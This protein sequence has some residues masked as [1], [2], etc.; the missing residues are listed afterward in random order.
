MPR[1]K[2]KQDVDPLQGF[3]IFLT[4]F[5][6]VVVLAIV[7]YSSCDTDHFANELKGK[8]AKSALKLTA[9]P[10]NLKNAPNPNVTHMIAQDMVLDVRVK[11]PSPD[12]VQ[13]TEIFHKAFDKN[14]AERIAIL[15]KLYKEL[16]SPQVVNIMFYCKNF[17]TFFKNWVMSC[18]KANIKTEKDFNLTDLI[19]ELA[20]LFY[21]K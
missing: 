12:T 13:R 10:K 15:K 16:G 8:V 18:Q 7:I 6:L 4:I 1:R 14:K 21:F 19:T 5:L 9:P 3:I 17:F 20:F 2:T 11:E